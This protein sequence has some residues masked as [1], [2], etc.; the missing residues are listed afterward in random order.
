VKSAGGFE[1]TGA[2]RQDSASRAPGPWGTSYRTERLYGYPPPR[3]DPVR[4]LEARVAE[5]ERR[6]ASLEAVLSK[7]DP[8]TE[9]WAS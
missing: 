7:D 6:I 8:R 9:T 3:R 4:D 1:T 2:R 5:L